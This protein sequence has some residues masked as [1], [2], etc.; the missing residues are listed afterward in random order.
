MAEPVNEEII[1]GSLF[2]LIIYTDE[3][4]RTEYF[5]EM[6]HLLILKFPCRVIFITCD[7]EADE[8]FIETNPLNAKGQCDR[9]KIRTSKSNLERVPFIILPHIVPDL[10]V[11][12]LWGEDP[13]KID[14][15][16]KPLLKIATRLIYDSES[17]NNLPSFSKN[18]IDLIEKL[19]IDFMDI[20]WALLR[21]WREL[22]AQTFNSS[23]NL[24]LLA[25]CDHV[26]ITYNALPSLFVERSTTKALYLQAWI[27]SRLKRKLKVTLIPTETPKLATG[28]LLKVEFLDD[29]VGVTINRLLDQPRA[30]IHVT[31]EEKCELPFT[32]PLPNHEKGLAFM[33]EIFY[34]RISDQYEKMLQE[35]NESIL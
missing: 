27:C 14:N 11:Y 5:H 8:N 1:K 28:S 15:S 7:P 10:P 20:D 22:I 19:N 31:T 6:V 16:L 35:L 12:F 3:P 32:Y 25:R 29:T 30:V 18:I 24:E 33:K 2:N 26:K 21:G 4:R 23:K 17:C 34:F 13:T 9:I